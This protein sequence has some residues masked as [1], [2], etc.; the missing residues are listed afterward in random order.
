MAAGILPTMPAKIMR[1]MPLPMPRSVILSPS[2]MTKIVPVMSVRTVWA[3][4]PMPGLG[5]TPGTWE[6]RPTRYWEMP[7]AWMKPRATVEYLVISFIFARPASPSFFSL[8]K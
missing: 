8:S 3:V 4:K 6:L 1:L 5:T 7:S 2:H